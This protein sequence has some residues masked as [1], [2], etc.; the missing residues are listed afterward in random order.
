MQRGV[1]SEPSQGDAVRERCDHPLGI[2]VLMLSLDTGREQ[3]V[4]AAGSRDAEV[5]GA[6]QERSKRWD[7]SYHFKW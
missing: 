7:G 1:L 4:R 5:P 2:Q 6:D 3:G